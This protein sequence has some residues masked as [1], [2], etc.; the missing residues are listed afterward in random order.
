MQELRLYSASDLMQK[1][2]RAN[3]EALSKQ[4]SS[5]VLNLNLKQALLDCGD[6]LQ[7]VMYDMSGN[8]KRPTLYQLCCADNRL[9][10]IGILIAVIAICCLVVNYF[11]AGQ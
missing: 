1:Q 5:K 8:T 10:G 3:A 7:G 11:L 4:N 6:A 2:E 9:R